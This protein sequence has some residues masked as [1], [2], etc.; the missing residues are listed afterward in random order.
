MRKLVGWAAH[1]RLLALLLC[2][3][4]ICLGG[5]SLAHLPIDAVPDVTNTQVQVVT[6]APALSASEMETQVTQIVERGMAGLPKLVQTRSITRLGI[7]IVTLVFDDD[8][9]VYFARAQANER[10]G[11]IREQIPE[12]IGKPQLGPI[13]TGLGEIFIFELK[14]T[15]KDPRSP[16]ELRTIVEWQIGP[17]LRQVPGVVE[18]IGYGGAL[19][20]YRVTLDPP[21]LSAHG[22]SVEEVRTALERENRVAGGGYVARSGE[23]ILLRADARFR[24]LEDIRAV[25]VRVDDDGVPVRL[26]QIA[27]V[28]TGPAL[29]QGAMSRD[30]RGEIVAASVLMLKGQNSR[31]VVAGVKKAIEE[32]QPYLPAGVTI[33]PYYDRAEF[34]DSVI[35]TI[36]KNLTEG[37]GIV[38]LCLL[39]TLGSIQAGLLVA[40]AIPFSMLVGFIGL[41]AIGY[42]GNVM[43]LGAVDFGI[44]VEG[45]VLSVEHAMAHGASEADRAIRREAI[46][47]AMQDVARPALF[48]VVITG[49]VFLPLSS[50]E[51]VEGRMFR[52]VVFSLCFMLL[53]AIFY[54][55]VFIPAIGP[56]LLKASAKHKDPAFSRWAK[57]LYGPVLDWVLARPKTILAA[58]AAVTI[59]LLSLGARMGADFMPRVFE[60]AFCID[61]LRPPSTSLEDALAL[62]HET[63]VTLKES[64]EVLTVINRIGRPEGAVDWQ[65]PESSD[66]FVML[67]PR[68]EWRHGMTPDKLMEEL[69]ARTDARVPATINSFSQPIEMRVNDL[70]AGARSDVVIKIFGEDMATMSDA[71]EKIRRALGQVPGA[72]NPKTELTVG[73]PAIRVDLD[74]DR[75]ARLGVTSG[76]V[77]DLLAM[78]RAGMTMGS[79]REGERMF[80]LTL[81]VGGEA[82]ENDADLARLP[83]ATRTGHLVPMGAVARI[84]E[85]NALVQVGREQMRRRLI[86]QCNV[87]GR[88]M[89]GFVKEAQQVVA[90]LDIPKTVEL[91]W[92]G[93]FQNF[94]RA[95]N[96]LTL[97]VPVALAVIALMLVVTFR[98]TKYMIITVLN[99]PFAMAGGVAALSIRDLP[100]SIPAGVGFI[101]LC[102]V[103]VCTGIV[104][105]N[106]LLARPGEP[107]VDRVKNAALASLRARMSTALIAAIGFV[108]AAIAT[109]TGAEVQRP[110]ATVVIGGLLASML[111]SLVALPAMLL[112]AARGDAKLGA[113]AKTNGTSRPTRE[114]E[115]DHPH[116]PVTAPAPSSGHI[117]TDN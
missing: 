9:D 71:A 34:I 105:T 97:L 14:P 102:G 40:G 4:V 104:M 11:I 65:G 115:H 54:A 84:T 27:D 81:R 38:I 31:D 95:K 39:L 85:E 67:K 110:L 114:H 82:V 29:R 107:P 48:V 75:L 36:T 21:R 91:Q 80:D 19:K 1:N 25:V 76:S 109:G 74:R 87:R 106:N 26:G 99:L 45:A 113:A 20:Q 79:V 32:M 64:P 116:E 8:A 108:P 59:A 47:R 66:V 86:V 70:I 55:L 94:T 103:S 60:G 50:L 89:V 63:E 78:S 73:Q 88:D 112:F 12:D 58:S 93:Q 90:K 100:F 5:F 22:I 46:I 101:A 43:S 24:G 53:G 10:L 3:I 83:V 62:A 117:M 6:R 68:S 30:G 2:T 16:E 56:S 77:L 42:S 96:R 35:K 13:A 69:S 49:L 18:V 98:S 15:A 61:A 51:G 92:G 28:D 44:I 37:A 52:P 17:R 41:H 72:A 57:R 23:Q 33:E 7:S 111:L